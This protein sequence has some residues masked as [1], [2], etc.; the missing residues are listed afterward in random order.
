MLVIVFMMRAMVCVSEEDHQCSYCEPNTFCFV[1]TQ[2]QCPPHSSS[3]AGSNNLTDCVCHS[4][5][6]SDPDESDCGDVCK[7]CEA[8]FRKFVSTDRYHIPTGYV[9]IE[10]GVKLGGKNLAQKYIFR[11]S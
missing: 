1:N 4:D 7:E 11:M 5:F 3:L 6:Y 10:N 8:D 2:Y 9:L